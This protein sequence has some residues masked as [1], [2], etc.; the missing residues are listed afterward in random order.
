MYAP[1]AGTIDRYGRYVTEGMA[2]QYQDSANEHN[3]RDQRSKENAEKRSNQMSLPNGMRESF[4][5]T[6][7]GE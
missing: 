6:M 4:Y 5:Q 7:S 3:R 2:Q 1:K